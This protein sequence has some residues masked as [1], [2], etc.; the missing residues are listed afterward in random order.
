M[1]VPSLSNCIPG[2]KPAA[3][4]AIVRSSTAKPEPV[5]VFVPALAF[6]AV[7]CVS[8]RKN[9][10]FES[11]TVKRYLVEV[12]IPSDS[13]A[14]SIDLIAEKEVKVFIFR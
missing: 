11:V 9:E 8:A 14:V 1:G 6:Q 2:D 7:S 3:A 13:I 12:R 5:G 4:C 10:I